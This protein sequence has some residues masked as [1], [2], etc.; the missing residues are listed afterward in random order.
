VQ[1]APDPTL[2]QIMLGQALIATNNKAHADE[3]IRLLEAAVRHESESPEAH[4]QMALAYGRAGDLAR[5]D[6][7]SALAAFVRGDMSTARALAIR[8]KTRFP[9][10]SPG[11]VRAD[12]ITSY[13]PKAIQRH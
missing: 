2:I 5:A 7:A 11:W 8:A 3:A 12:D 9:V 13:R 1:F 10:G 6:L 4:T